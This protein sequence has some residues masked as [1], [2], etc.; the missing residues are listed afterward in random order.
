MAGLRRDL[1]DSARPMIAIATVLSPEPPPWIWSDL[2]YHTDSHL[3]TQNGCQ[4]GCRVQVMD[5]I[6]AT[7]PEHQRVGYD[8]GLVKRRN[9]PRLL[10]YSVPCLWWHML[11]HPATLLRDTRYEVKTSACRQIIRPPLHIL[12]EGAAHQPSTYSHSAL[13]R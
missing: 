2:Q 11:S 13:P 8:R 1:G 4:Q 10:I 9:E 7:R 3:I 12:Q 5:S 6:V